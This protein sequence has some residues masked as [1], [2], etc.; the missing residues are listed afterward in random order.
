MT[1]IRNLRL[2]RKA[3]AINLTLYGGM[4]YGLTGAGSNRFA[5]ILGGMMP[6]EPANV[7]IGGI[8]LSS[9]RKRIAFIPDPPFFCEELTPY[10]FLCLSAKMRGADFR[11]LRRIPHLLEEGDLTGVRNRAIRRLT[12][13]QKKVLSVLYA[14]AG[15][16]ELL[17][18]LDLFEGIGETEKNALLQV[19]DAVRGEST[20]VLT[21]TEEKLAPVCDRIL[22]F[23]EGKLQTDDPKTPAA[24]AE[25]TVWQLRVSGERDAILRALGKVKGISSCR[26]GMRTDTGERRLTLTAEPVS[27]FDA[28]LRD[29][30][31]GEGCDLKELKRE[32]EK[33]L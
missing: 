5:E 3:D 15:N 22:R 16:P 1:E 28:I 19:L 27:G 26:F 29:A 31:A 25:E 6:T 9:A 4:T 2:D 7:R 8:E 21:G 14:A 33:T 30:L 12:G 13:W 32:G 23:R 17:I 10:E 20:V 24:G 11:Q 18:F